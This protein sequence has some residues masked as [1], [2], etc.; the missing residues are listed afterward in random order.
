M[1]KKDKLEKVN[2]VVKYRVYS[3]REG[4]IHLK[5]GT[6]VKFEEMS[7]VS[8]EDMEL[9]LKSYPDYIKRVD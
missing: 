5:D 6:I 9:L 1:A 3:K 7:Q 2:P 4:D 8:K